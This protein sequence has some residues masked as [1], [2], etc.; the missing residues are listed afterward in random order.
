MHRMLKPGGTLYVSVPFGKHLK[1]GWF[2]I[3]DS[4]MVERVINTFGPSR[5]TEFHYRYEPAGWV[6]STRE[7]SADATYFDIHKT[8][9]YDP[10]YAAA[11]RAVVCL[12]L[13]K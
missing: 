10:D 3:F 13:V 5:V 4:D 1:C 6:A 8:K 9:Q 11:S 2:Q 7:Q 12:E